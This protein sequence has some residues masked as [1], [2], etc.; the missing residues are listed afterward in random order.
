[1]SDPINQVS[2]TLFRIKP[3]GSDFA[4][5]YEMTELDGRAPR[6][7]VLMLGG[8]LYS[9]ASMGGINGAG[10]IFRFELLGTGITTDASPVGWS[11]YPDPAHSAI[12]LHWDEPGKL[13]TWE[14]CDFQGRTVLT[15]NGSGT[16]DEQ[17]DLSGLADGIYAVVVHDARGVTTQRFVKY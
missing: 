2:G 4:M 3:D 12:T 5:L 11:L 16:T 17:M 8:Y 1:M 13:G 6:D 7:Q 10:T 9:A 14:V 15:R